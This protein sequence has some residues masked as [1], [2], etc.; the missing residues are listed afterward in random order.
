MLRGGKGNYV[1]GSAV[2]MGQVKT[3]EER[4]SLKIRTVAGKCKAKQSLL[5]EP[6][7]QKPDYNQSVW[8]GV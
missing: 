3:G 6:E 7:R 1:R 2:L 5:G 4:M 8:R